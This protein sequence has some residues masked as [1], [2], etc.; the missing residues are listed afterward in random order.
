[1]VGTAKS[2]VKKTVTVHSLV[3]I[4]FLGHKPGGYS[5]VVNHIDFDKT[6]NNLR[7]LELTTQRNNANKKHLKSK[8]EYTGVCWNKPA[9]KWVS[10]ITLNGKNKY[11]GYF[12]NEIDAHNAYQN[13]L[14]SL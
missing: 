12:V 14:N 3:A 1:M 7:N 5:I 6:N 9:N 13:E 11:L 2:G 4:A 8:S 10:C